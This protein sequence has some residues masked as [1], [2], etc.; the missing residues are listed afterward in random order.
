MDLNF[1]SSLFEWIA[2]I[3]P[4]IMKCWWNVKIQHPAPTDVVTLGWVQVSGSLRSEPNKPLYL[5]TGRN[6]YFPFEVNIDA[7]TK[8]WNGQVN[9]GSKN[10]RQKPRIM[11]VMPDDGMRY[12]IQHYK[13]FANKCEHPGMTMDSFPENLQKLDEVT[14]NVD[15]T[16]PSGLKQSTI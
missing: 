15:P 2:K 8:T 16:L 7:K 14:V 1:I 6:P 10:E 9:L 11:I 12:F 13:K 3:W 4:C 5:I